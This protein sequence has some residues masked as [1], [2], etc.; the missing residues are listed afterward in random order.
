MPTERTMGIDGLKWTNAS[1]KPSLFLIL[2]TASSHSLLLLY[3]AVFCNK[4]F[5]GAQRS[6]KFDMNLP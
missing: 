5:S 3:V 2:W 1:A 6:D 4:P